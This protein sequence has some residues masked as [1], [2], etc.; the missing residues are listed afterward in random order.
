MDPKPFWQ[1]KTLWA[2]VITVVATI[3]AL[4]EVTGLLSPDGL[5]VVLVVQ[6]ALNVVL[7]FLTV[8]AVTNP[9]ADFFKK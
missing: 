8:G 2:N 9:I 7:R 6:G 5:K 4:P 3:L 1:S